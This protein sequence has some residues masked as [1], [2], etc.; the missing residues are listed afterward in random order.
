MIKAVAAVLLAAVVSASSPVEQS[1]DMQPLGRVGSGLRLQVDEKRTICLEISRELKSDWPIF[2][3]FYNWNKNG[4]NLFTTELTAHCDG[5]VLLTLAS[6][7]NW[8]GSTEFYPRDIIHVQLSTSAPSN[9]HAAV[10]CHEL[11]HVLG[12][13]HSLGDGSCMDH[14]QNNPEPTAL[15]LSTVGAQ[16][17]SSTVAQRTML[18]VK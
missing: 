2:D 16:P 10:V 6:N 17:W 1:V 3:A 15:N 5:F 13:P 14:N 18:G 12:L 9:S 4:S 11:G 7:V 8:W